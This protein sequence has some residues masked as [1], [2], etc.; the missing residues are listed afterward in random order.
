MTTRKTPRRVARA[1]ATPGPR[2]VFLHYSHAYRHAAREQGVEPL[3][4]YAWLMGP[5][6]E[7]GTTGAGLMRW[8]DNWTPT[9]DP[10]E[11][12]LRCIAQAGPGLGMDSLEVRAALAE[13]LRST[14]DPRPVMVACPVRLRHV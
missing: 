4:R 7:P 5:G 9:L 1:L 12:A 3:K 14:N 11:I 13:A 2:G 8:R 6:G 10:H